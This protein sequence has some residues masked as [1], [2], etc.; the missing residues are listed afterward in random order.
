MFSEGI[1]DPVFDEMPLDDVIWD[2]ADIFDEMSSMDFVWDDE[3]LSEV[4]LH[5]SVLEQLALSANYVVCD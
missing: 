3:L 2:G 5:D 4:E 1:A